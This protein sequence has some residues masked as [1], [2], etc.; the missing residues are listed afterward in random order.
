MFNNAEQQDCQEMFN[1]TSTCDMLDKVRSVSPYVI[2]LKEPRTKLTTAGDR[3]FHSAG[4]KLW[5]RLP[6]EI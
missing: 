4:P 3:S 1:I 2:T 6:N 5:N